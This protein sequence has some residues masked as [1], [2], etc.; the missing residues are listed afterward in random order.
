M[1]P[2]RV[3]LKNFLSFGD[4]PAVFE[5]ADGDP[6]WVVRGPNGV[7]KSAVFDAITYALYGEHRGGQ[8]GADQLVRHGAN[9]FEV[10]FDF[11]FSGA[12]YR[13][14]RTRSGR[15]GVRAT[16]QLLRREDGGGFVPM[17]AGD[18]A[19][20]DTA[21]DIKRWVTATLGLG[22]EAFTKSV[23]LRQ[24]KADEL[25]QAGRAERLDVLK[26]VMGFER[27]E[28]L[29][30]R[31]HEAARDQDRAAKAADARLAEQKPVAADE[32]A[33]AEEAVVNTEAAAT[34]ARAA[35]AAA[36]GR[37]ERAV[38]W[39]GLDKRRAELDGKLA[40]ADE[41]AARGRQIRE[42]KQALDDLTAAVPVLQ[43]LFGVRV[44]LTRLSTDRAAAEDR[45]ATAAADRDAAAA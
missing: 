44:R 18:S 16:Q 2:L 26:R 42:Q 35:L 25:F 22:C 19:G 45:R 10:E 17:R 36:A 15:K 27:F 33:A 39:E 28:A 34:D 41:R 12:V 23:L 37:V 3:S 43:D 30:R 7:G 24:G 5:F 14:R 6:L 29:S 38:A 9:A 1:I 32:V 40:A 21:D 20:A 11:E 31:V 4:E 8:H 13:V